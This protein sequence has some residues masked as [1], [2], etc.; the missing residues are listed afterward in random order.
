M[1]D[2]KLTLFELHLHGD[3]QFGPN[4]G[5][6]LGS[7]GADEDDEADEDGEPDIEIE[8]GDGSP[9]KGL[10][11]LVALVVVVVLVR[12]LLGGDDEEFEDDDE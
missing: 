11:G 3:N 5:E 6:Q 2:R 12:R 10:L 4:I 8:A 7:G 9:V 1:G